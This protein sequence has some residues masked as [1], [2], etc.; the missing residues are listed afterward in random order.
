MRI[1]SR[2]KEES[3]H[4]RALTTYAQHS[5]FAEFLWRQGIVEC[6]VQCADGAECA[7]ALNPAAYNASRANVSKD[8]RD[9][10]ADGVFEA[11]GV[12]S[13][14]AHLVETWSGSKSVA[15]RCVRS[16]NES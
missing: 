13:I 4:R 5:R 2:N 14:N 16:K 3:H 1:P 11:S 7:C 15:S 9:A 12:D 10:I 6:P 8:A